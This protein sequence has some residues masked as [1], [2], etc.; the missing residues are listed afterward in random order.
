MLFSLTLFNLV[1]TAEEAAFMDLLNFMYGNTLTA[2]TPP[3]L[4]DVLMVADKF[5]VVSCMRYC[6]RL[7]RD[8]PMTRKSALLYLDL[9][10][11]VMIADAIQPLTEAARQFLAEFYKDI[12]K[13][14]P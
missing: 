14:V 10:S 6:G 8:L 11:S 5:E 13:L 4:F 1:L 7:L 2:R 12:L 3:A 9:P